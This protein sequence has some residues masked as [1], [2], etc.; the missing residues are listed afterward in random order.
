MQLDPT[1]IETN[2]DIAPCLSV[3]A[4]A[5]NEAATVAQ[6]VRRVLEQKPLQEVIVVDD[7]STDKT[8]EG[9][10]QFAA[11][12]PRVKLLRRE[13]NQGKG[14]ALRTGFRET[15]PP[16]VIVPDA[17]LEYA[18]R[19]YY[20]LLRPILAGQADVVY[21][22][23]FGGS[24]AHRVLYYWHSVGN[25][26]LTTLSNMTTN[27]NLTDMETGYKAF[28][29]E[30]IQRIQIEESRFGFEPE[31]TAKVARL[32]VP[33]YEV[34]ISY[35][36]RTDEEGK[37]SAGV[38]ASTPCVASSNTFFFQSEPPRYPHKSRTGWIG[39]FR[40]FMNTTTTTPVVGMPA[41]CRWHATTPD[42]T[43][44]EIRPFARFWLRVAGGEHVLHAGLDPAGAALPEQGR[45]WFVG[46]DRDN[47]GLR[48]AGRSGHE[49][50]DRAH[51]H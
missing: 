39:I 11:L 7:A 36:G 44:Q 43:L 22:T 37:E 2:A 15:T 31:I 33:V 19:E 24:S 32:K 25:R 4:P 27:L 1:F 5:F 17:D 20:L 18:P 45:V 21:G 8:W 10:Q 38:T 29:R 28:K 12:A 6:T 14:A 41:R 47:H 42:V 34:A 46:A 51:P 9:L 49:R 48:P 40:E 50:L 30:V 3:V 13:K 35:Y 16:V 26:L 23:R